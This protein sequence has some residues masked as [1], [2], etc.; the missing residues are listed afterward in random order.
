MPCRLRY[1]AKLSYLSF[2]SCRKISILGKLFHFAPKEI[3]FPFP[4]GYNVRE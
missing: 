4:S 1:L 3:A 2:F